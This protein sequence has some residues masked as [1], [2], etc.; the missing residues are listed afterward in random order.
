MSDTTAPTVGSRDGLAIV[1]KTRLAVA[2]C[3]KAV[4]QLH[5]ESATIY[6]ENAELAEIAFPRDL[7]ILEALID[8]LDAAGALMEDEDEWAVE[9]LN[10]ARQ[11]ANVKTQELSGGE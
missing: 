3:A 5:S 11:M 1:E 9:V 6:G 10:A 4:L 8:H 7:A 2:H